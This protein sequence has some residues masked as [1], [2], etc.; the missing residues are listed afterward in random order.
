MK[1]FKSFRE[2]IRDSTA[3]FENLPINKYL[4]HISDKKNNETL[5]EHTELVKDYTLLLIKNHNLDTIVNIIINEAIQELS[6]KEYL[7]T[8]IK[9]IF[10]SSIVF[11]DA[12]K[13]NPNFQAIRMNN[14]AFKEDRTLTF[15]HNHS[16]L[17]AF[18]LQNFFYEKIINETLFT[19]DQKILLYYLVSIITNSINRHHS[20][21][22]DVKKEFKDYCI[23]EMLPFLGKY[24]I[25]LE[26]NISLSFYTE[27]KTLEETFKEVFSNINYFA[28]FALLKLNYSL[29]TASDYYATSEYMNNLEVADFGIIDSQLRKRIINS[30]VCN[31]EKPYNKELI[32]NT[33]KYTELPFD[34]LQD[35]NNDN[36]NLL[37]QKIASE[38]IQNL[39]NNENKNFFYLEA[40]TGSGKTNISIAIATEL[41][42]FDEHLSKI[43]YVFPF[44]T[45]VDQTFK[46]IKDTIEVTDDEIIQL[47]SKS[48]FPSKDSEE[49]YYG[50]EYKNYIDYLF[51]NYPITVLTH[52]RFFDIL[53]GNTKETNYLLHRL[54]NSIVIIDELQSYPP[55]HWDKIVYFLDNYAKLFNI[56]VLIMSATLPKIDELNDQSK[57][58]I[59]ELVTNRDQYFC[60]PNFGKRISFEIIQWSKPKVNEEKKVFLNKLTELILEKSEEYAS[61]NNNKVRTVIEFISKRTASVFLKK[62]NDN[63]RYNEYAK[64]L[65]SGEILEG[66]RKEIINK[67]KNEDDDKIIVV[68]TQVI[69]AGV[70]IDMDIGF[71]DRSLIDSEEQLAGRINRE[72]KKKDCKLY[73]FDLDKTK[74]IYGKD[75][76]Y[77]IQSTDEWIEKNYLSI[78][79]K[80]QYKE[81]YQRVN[82]RLRNEFQ[83][84]LNERSHYPEY[85]KH[86]DLQSIDQ[87]FK[88]ID[89]NTKSLFIPIKINRRYF[90]QSDLAALSIFPDNINKVSGEEVFEKYIEL[91]ENTEVDFTS[92]NIDLKKM[93]GIL[94]Q[95][96]I[97]VFPNQLEKIRQYTDSKERYGYEYLI[98]WEKIYSL[99]S[100]F[101]MDKIK[102]DIFL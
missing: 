65:I 61:N 30:F 91:V 1:S 6:N 90:N 84:S 14:E 34:K 40:P 70:D 74:N 85:F 54:A 88:L 22:V 75:Y 29:L 15:K 80:K 25:K 16:F 89:Q 27:Y 79:N 62:L 56:K 5:E 97:S 37:R 35:R 68:T 33:K 45:L 69:E 60:N 102:S 50:C 94:S 57:G 81:L 21:Y 46:S 66:R 10:I 72:A 52:I 87:K 23:K 82:H 20:S 32:E 101:D 49:G 51:V 28:L 2:I 41:L 3:L 26:D 39:R 24:N 4:A 19:E 77:E 47:H 36:L 86:L 38:A 78:L 43:F 67:I 64:Y 96:I 83:D 13:I 8:F 59:V 7:G 58:K 11:H 12:G 42:K 63:S 93:A 53:K 95:F 71:K 92:K 18:I 9:E 44:T 100:G 48:G 76:R 98:N 31:T 73:I 99:N 17:G 55:T